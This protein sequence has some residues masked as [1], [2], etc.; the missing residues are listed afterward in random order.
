VKLSYISLVLRRVAHSM[1]DLLWTH[2]LTSGTMAMTLFVFGG[3]LLL[4]ENLRAFTKGWGDQIQ[5]IAYLRDALTAPEL[6]SLLAQLRAFP[7]VAAIRYVSQEKAWDEFK[8]SLGSQSSLL[9]GLQSNILPASFE[10]TLKSPYRGREALKNLTTRLKSAPGISDVEYSEEWT[11]RL[12][13]IL[14]GIQWGKWIFGGLLFFA[15]LF[16]IGN[17]VKLAILARREEIEI[18]QLVGA[19]N[20]VIKAP[21]ILEG[22]IQGIFG[23]L[24]SILALGFL[25]LLFGAQLP[26]ALGALL[27]PDELRFL[28]LRS[29]LLLLLMGWTL[30]ACGSLLAVR[31]FFHT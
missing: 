5:I 13:L 30:G 18:M 7:E 26:P 15:T 14:L 24:F 29:I 16:I 20:A 10:I 23:S 31:R 9:E 21:F 19:V 4:Q 3:F 27:P 12:H 1:K 8:R 28:D 22:M 2:M 25:F 6:Q 11:E 17:T